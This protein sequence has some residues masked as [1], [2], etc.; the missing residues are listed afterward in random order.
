MPSRYKP[1][2]S[3]T[4]DG[5]PSYFETI[6]SHVMFETKKRSWVFCHTSRTVSLLEER[7]P[8]CCK[9]RPCTQFSIQEHYL[10]DKESGFIRQLYTLVVFR[11]AYSASNLPKAAEK[12]YKIFAC[13]SGKQ[14]NPFSFRLSSFSCRAKRPARCERPAGACFKLCL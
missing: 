10:S 13:F 4:Q 14:N 1:N 12:P 2:K 3:K 11:K 5:K 6:V 7:A 9:P 8:C